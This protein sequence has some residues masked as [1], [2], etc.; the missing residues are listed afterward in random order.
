MFG[1][2]D[3]AHLRFSALILVALFATAVAVNRIGGREGPPLPAAGSIEHHAPG[4]LVREQ[5]REAGRAETG[6]GGG[7]IL[8]PGG[9]VNVNEAGAD[10]L[11]ALPGIGP[12]RSRLILEERKSG[13]PFQSPADM[14]RVSG[15]GPKTVENLRPHI[16][17]GN[18]PPRP[19]SAPP[20]AGGGT[21]PQRPVRVN[22]AGSEEL[23]RLN[24]VGPAIAQRIIDERNTRGLFRSPEDML[25]VSGIGPSFL[26]ANRHV[27]V[28]D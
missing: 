9:V 23:Q 18:P 2:F 15:I 21:P 11:Q 25:R 4:Q 28:F 3:L 20:V 26:E 22:H 10:L 19:P 6:A 5:D 27:M 14:E 24:R 7:G 8:E 12:A 17:V 1:G 16:T 13:G